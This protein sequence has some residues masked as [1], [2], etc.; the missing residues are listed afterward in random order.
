MNPTTECSSPDDERKCRAHP[1]LW[2]LRALAVYGAIS[3]LLFAV[4][5]IG[6]LRDAYLGQGSDPTLFSWFLVWWPRALIHRLNPFF[7]NSLWAPHGINLA[8][9]TAIPLPALVVSP[10]TIGFGPIVAFNVLC[11]FGSPVSGWTAFL[12]YRHVSKS[13]WASLVGGYIFGFSA[14]MAGHQAYGQVNLTLV[15]LIPLAALL[16]AQG[17]SSASNPRRLVLGLVAILIAQ[18]FI[19]IEVFATMVVA[20]GFAL[21]LGWSFAPQETCE[22]LRKLALPILAAFAIV[23][24]LSS[25]YLY[26]LFFL[27]SFHGAMWSADAYS[28]D[29][30]NFAIPVPTTAIGTLPLLNHLTRQFRSG[31]FIAEMNGY[32]GPPLMVIVGLYAWQ[33]FREPLGRTLVEF[34]IICMVLSLGPRLRI[35]GLATIGLPFKAFLNLPLLDK[36]LPSRFMMYG[37]LALGLITTLWLR[38]AQIGVR[39]KALVVALVV[40]STFPSPSSRWLRPLNSPKFFADKAYRQFLKRT[41][42]VLML[43]FG[44]RGDSMLWHAET[45][46]YFKMVGGWT[47]PTP[48]EFSQWPIVDAFAGSTYIPDAAEQMAAL[49]AHYAVDIVIVSLSDPDAS[50]WDGVLSP[51]SSDKQTIGGVNMYRI[52]AVAVKPYG[53]AT[54]LEMRSR[55]NQL[56]IGHLILAAD[57]WRSRGNRPTVLTP[58]KAVQSHLLKDSWFLGPNTVPGWVV[59][60]VDQVIDTTQHLRGGAWLGGTPGGDSGVGLY[61]SYAALEPTIAEYRAT[62]LHIYFP[63]PNDLLSPGSATPTADTEALL[64]LVFDKHQLRRAA[65][66]LRAVQPHENSTLTTKCAPL[67]K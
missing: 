6:H 32:I 16:L 29:L 17:I 33:R 56:A 58:S 54:Q 30:L 15:F 5:L 13:W 4:P 36:A 49:L 19:S 43:P 53:T 3:F 47:G 64:T 8:W 18:F 48:E 22:R 37:F 61:G 66:S 1:D 9:T 31:G 34:L 28:N 26:S 11:L 2:G 40:I 38:S 27:G 50:S 39:A 60:G 55:L 25:P 35:N 63:Y 20:G 12:L 42:T 51:V 23:M 52:S 65:S 10:I 57:Q 46:M 67:G 21:L 59:G 7:T 14:Y 24:L 44:I 62:A 45:G 41:D